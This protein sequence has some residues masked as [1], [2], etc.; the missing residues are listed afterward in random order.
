MNNLELKIKFVDCYVLYMV[1]NNPLACGMNVLINSY[2]KLVLKKK[3]VNP[4]V[5]IKCSNH[6]F[7]ILGL[8]VDDYNILV[9][10]NIS[11]VN[12]T[13]IKLFNILKLTN[14]GNFIIVLAFKSITKGQTRPFKLI[15]KNPSW[16]SFSNLGWK[17]INQV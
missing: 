9:F 5:Y 1:S 4:N 17:F 7:V 2:Y 13:K 11:F 12:T 16:K 8:Y 10:I 15:K 6:M 14:N 3:K